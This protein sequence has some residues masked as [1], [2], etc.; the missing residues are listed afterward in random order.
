MVFSAIF[1][2]LVANLMYND[3]YSLDI[4]NTFVSACNNDDKLLY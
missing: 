4:G 1:N 3:K 2:N